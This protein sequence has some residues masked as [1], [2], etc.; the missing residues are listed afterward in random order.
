MLKE[1]RLEEEQGEVLQEQSGE[2]LEVAVQPEPAKQ[3][4]EEVEVV[5][6][7]GEEW[8]SLQILMK[9]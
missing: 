8:K 4:L 1:V 3:L 2:E 7:E 6:L 5:A 9:K